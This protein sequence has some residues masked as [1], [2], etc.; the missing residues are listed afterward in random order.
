MM[1]E[2]VSEW[3]GNKIMI[4]RKKILYFRKNYVM[5]WKNFCILEKIIICPEKFLYVRQ[6]WICSENFLYVRK[7][8]CNPRSPLITGQH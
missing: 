8:F 3:L 5:S 7:K 4:C 1:S 6:N 2:N